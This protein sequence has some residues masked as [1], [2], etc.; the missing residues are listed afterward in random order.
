MQKHGYHQSTSALLNQTLLLDEM[1]QKT[2]SEEEI[3]WIKSHRKVKV[4]IDPNWAPLEFVNEQG[5]FVGI[6]PKFLD[7]IR[8]QTGIEFEPA[9][10]LTW[11]QAVEAMQ[12]GELDMYSAVSFTPERSTYTLYTDPYLNFPMVI[13]TQ[14]NANFINDLSRLTDKTIA[15]VEDYASQENMQRFFPNVPLMLVAT[16]QEGVEAVSKGEA[17]GYIDNVAIITHYIN[18]NN[19]TN[20]QISGETP[21]RSDVHM[22]VRKDWPELQSILNKLFASMPQQVKNDITD[23][24]LKV[25]YQKVFQW[26]EILWVIV[27]VAMFILITSYYSLRLRSINANL[28]FAQL[29]LEETN[30]SLSGLSLTDHLT[31]VYNR[32]HLDKTINQEIER[33]HRYGHEFSILIMDLD[34]F[35]QVNDTHGHLVGDE[36]LI[37]FSAWISSMIR[38]SDTFGRWGGEEFLLVCPNTTAEQAYQLG[39]KICIGTRLQTYPKSIMQTV[40]IGVTTFQK[41]QDAEQLLERADEALYRA[42]QNGRN[43]TVIG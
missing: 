38:S 1:R 40:S 3:A 19:Y 13:A 11:S 15:V 18:K 5:E 26:T 30:R 14:R 33:A 36:V 24:W 25:T 9:T 17:F 27:P 34:Y 43:R 10:H 8:H 29:Q 7:Y 2:F 21:F 20:L 23:S 35:K 32:K 16:P 22:A 39:E 42:K 37:T 12:K 41:G 6:A 28:K 4:A 31:G